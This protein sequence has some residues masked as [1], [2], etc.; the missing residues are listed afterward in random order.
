[1]NRTSNVVLQ[2]AAAELTQLLRNVSGVAFHVSAGEGP[3]EGYRFDLI[4]D[5]SLP[6]RTVR[7]HALADRCEIRGQSPNEVLAGVYA[8]LERLGFCFTVRGPVPPDAVVQALPVFT[9]EVQ[10]QVARRGI[11]QHIN[12]PMD[13]SSYPLAEAQE[14]IRNLARMRMNTMTFHLY[15]ACGWYHQTLAGRKSM[16]SDPTVSVPTAFY[17]E[18]HRVPSHPPALAHIR[19]RHCFCRPEMEAIYGTE[20]PGRTRIIFCKCCFAKRNGM[21]CMSLSAWKPLAATWRNSLRTI[22]RKSKTC[23][24]TPPSMPLIRRRNY[25][26]RQ[27]SGN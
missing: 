9:G 6:E 25:T 8:Y 19:N 18:K 20:P 14:Y 1:M 24:W 23:G 3:A 5:A 21:V 27:M 13:I 15:E 2:T 12:F 17:S 26:G 22:A 10:A 4:H 16:L 7:L 11:R